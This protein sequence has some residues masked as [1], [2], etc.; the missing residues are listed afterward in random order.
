MSGR[1]IA[2]RYEL[3]AILGQGGMGQVWTAYDRRLDRRVAVKLLRPDR[4]AGPTGS[5]AAD[6]LRRRFVRECRVTAQVDHPGLV[7]VHDAGSDGDDLYLVM[8]YVEGADLADHLA[9]Q[10][11][12]PWPWAVAVA[13]QLCAVLCAV[14]AVPIVHRDLKPR[15]VM[16]RP[17]GTVTVLDLGVASV[18]D[19]DTTRLTHTGSP[20]GSPAYMAPEQAMG[21]AVGPYTD[22][23]ALGVLL[24]EL[25]SGDVPFAGST[26]LGVLHRHLYEAPVPVRQKRPEV[27]VALEALVLRLLAK[28]PQDRPASAQEVYEELAPLLPKHGTPAGPLDP[29]RPFLRPHA[30]WPDRAAT[31]AAVPAP[32]TFA[33][34]PPVL[35]A[36]RP[37]LGGPPSF[38]GPPAAFPTP[39]QA[40]PARPTTPPPGR[41]D[42][43]RAVDEVKKLLGEGR[44]TQAVD[45]LGATLPAAAAEHG[46]HSPVVRI[47]RKQYAA[48]LMD[49]GQYRRALPELRR[50]AEDRTAEA[51]PADSQALQFRYDAAQCLEQLGEA[52]AALVEYRAV[53]PYY[54]NAYGPITSD[55]G[56]ALDIRHRIGQLLLAV[57][58]HTAGRAQLQAL[59][60]DA[61]RTYGPHHPLPLDLRRLL[62][63]QRDVRGG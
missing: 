15:N 34:P 35:P 31:P 40:T 26:A 30:P 7:T 29:T 44:I 18:L 12:Y 42:V 9:E 51:G 58:D 14:H 63:H 49:D 52:G 19:T 11:P 10:D 4:V 46:E 38:T 22:L 5:D 60:Y 23:Y 16:V 43:A 33:A 57:G 50:L 32:A 28:D 59:L 17:D 55:P 36:T 25:L 27:P 47:L 37:T 6:E 41:L 56:R 53:L 48:T 62:S 39:A 13:A 3:A 2:D 61:E 21:G 20:I 24:H 1:T 45:V 54:E 8:Q